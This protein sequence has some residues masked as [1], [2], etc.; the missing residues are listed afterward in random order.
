LAKDPKLANENWDRFLPKFKK[1]NVQRRVPLQTK[2]ENEAKKAGKAKPPKEYT[3]FPPVRTSTTLLQ[4]TALPPS[5]T[6]TCSD[7]TV[8]GV[9]CA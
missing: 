8:C 1:K 9:W 4:L 6:A 2:K 7:S 3:P 5:S